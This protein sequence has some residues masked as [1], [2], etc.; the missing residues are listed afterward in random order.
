MKLCTCFSARDN[1]SLRP[2]T[3]TIV[4][5]QHTPFDREKNNNQIQLQTSWIKFFLIKK[6]TIKPDTTQ[7]ARP[8]Y[9]LGTKS[10]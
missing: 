8:Q 1:S 4:A 10:P 9:V 2:S 7:T 3:A 5:V 6:R